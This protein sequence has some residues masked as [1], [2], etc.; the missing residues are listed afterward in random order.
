[1]SNL[2]TENQEFIITYFAKSRDKEITRKAK[3]DNKCLISK[4][5]L[6][7]F[8]TTKKGYRRA[9]IPF[10]IKLNFRKGGK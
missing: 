10:I 6:T 5:Y 4:K 3:W 8:D 1:M 9:T 2:F 7:Y